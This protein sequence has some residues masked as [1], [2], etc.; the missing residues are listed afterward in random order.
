MHALRGGR[1]CPRGTAAV[2]RNRRAI[3]GLTVLLPVLVML[4]AGTRAADDRTD[5]P[6]AWLVLYLVAGA[7]AGG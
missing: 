1:P 6:G 3:A 4:F 7:R 5:A 2:V